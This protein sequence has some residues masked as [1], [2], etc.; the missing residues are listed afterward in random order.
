VSE[1]IGTASVVVQRTSGVDG[2]IAV[3]YAVTG[4]TASDGS[5]YTSVS[6]TLVFEDGETTKSIALPI[7]NN[8]TPESP[9]TVI[10]TLTTP[11]LGARLGAAATFTVTMSDDDAPLN[12]PPTVTIVYP[13]DQQTYVA[14]SALI[15]LRGNALDDTGIAT[16]TWTNNRG[17]SGVAQGTSP[18]TAFDIPLQ[19]GSN[20]ITVT[21]TDTGGAQASD[22]IRITA[23]ELSYLLAEGAT[24]AFF[25]LDILL[26]NPHATPAP[27]TVTFLKEG[28]STVVQTLTL[29]ATSR[30]T[31]RVDQIAGLEGTAVST[32]VTSTAGLPLVVERTMRWDASGYGAHTEKAV[33]APATTWYFAEGSQGFFST[34][35]LLANPDTNPN[36][37]E[38]LYLREGTS[39]VSRTY[40]L[41]P[42]S[43]VTVD[44]GAD[45]ALVNQS[46]G[47]I[48][49]FDAPGVAERAMY[50][51]TTPLWRAGHESAG[52]TQPALEWFL[53][54]GATGSFFETFI[55][56]ANPQTTSDAEV[57]LTYLR[58]SG[59]PITQTKT[60]PA[61]GRL[62]VN[63]EY[64]DP[65]LANTAFGT[66][67]VSSVPI[68]VERAQYWPG[69]PHSWDEAHNSFG[70][71]SLGTKWGL[72][73]GR[74]GGAN[75]YQTYI[76]LANPGS[77]PANATITFLRSNGSTV[78]KSFTVDPFS[79]FNVAPGPGGL[80]PELSN[81]EFAAVIESS[82]PI[83]VERAMYLDVGGVTWA[84][85]TNATATRLP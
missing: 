11:M 35:I 56:L 69:A 28:G 80:V 39:P 53:A 27:V 9:E 6:G 75:N 70:T 60:I 83:A 26:A 82:R 44:A 78:T 63:A 66:Q 71:V 40:D 14:Q 41:A 62:T 61:A 79:R 38:I 65:G 47:M 54:E 34:Y 19:F 84:A 22:M 58:S 5:D 10:L 52:V 37:A 67:V 8:T 45:P 33:E 2:A 32:I 7:V 4:G 68:V 43:R 13:T 72:A 15:T 3:D 30:T 50:F 55:L 12:P 64:E 76:L 23:T 49:T 59:A 57:T 36:R 42:R 81:E 74:V 29:P 48:V 73:E 18:W 21:A 1:N 25:D 77:T 20:L 24:G 85:G 31:L 16:V 46:F 17:G 51:G